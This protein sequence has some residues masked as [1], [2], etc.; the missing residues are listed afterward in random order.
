M[1]NR[2]I[3]VRFI[4]TAALVFVAALVVNPAAFADEAGKPPAKPA[5]AGKWQSL[6]DGKTLTGWK[7]T[8]Y[9]GEG[10]VYVNKAGDL[11]LDMGVTLT[12]VHLDG[13]KFPTNNY[14]IE[15]DAR[16][17]EGIDFF[18]GLT[19]PVDKSHCS[20]IVGGWAGAVVG[21]SSIDN[22][23]ASENK[24]T[25]YRN[26]KKNQ[27]YKFKVQV[28]PGRIQCWI[29]GKQVVNADVKGKKL[30]VRNEM[31]P[32]RPLGLATFETRAGIRNIRYRELHAAKK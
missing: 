3:R 26:F 8:N 5:K 2:Q 14:E 6:F 15:L 9:G 7:K 24:T 19:F 29:D 12:G 10:E 30:T 28:T 4:L 21:I 22:K 16:R 32:S 20:F 25:I 1:L 17:M 18:V 27:W 23:D 31:L 11:V 13:G